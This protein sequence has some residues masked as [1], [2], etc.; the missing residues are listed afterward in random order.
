M[1]MWPTLVY[2]SWTLRQCWRRGIVN[3]VIVDYLCFNNGAFP[4]SDF[5][6]VNNVNSLKM[7]VL[8]SMS[9]LWYL[10]CRQIQ[11]FR[12]AWLFYTLWLPILFRCTLMRSQQQLITACSLPW[13]H[14]KLS[15][16]LVVNMTMKDFAMTA[17]V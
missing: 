5:L 17:T 15:T 10:F 16:R 4:E 8:Y 14:Q 11:T 1:S 6:F 13:L 12:A 3:F 9:S 7:K 2:Q